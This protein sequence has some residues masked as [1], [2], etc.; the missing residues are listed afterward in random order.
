MGGALAVPGG[1][2]RRTSSVNCAESGT[3][4]I[5]TRDRAAL[6]PVFAR[7]VEAIVHGRALAHTLHEDTRIHA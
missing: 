5:T 6:A 3:L 4:A 7:C 2:G 1:C